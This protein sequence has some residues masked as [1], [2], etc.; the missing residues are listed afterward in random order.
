MQNNNIFY[1]QAQNIT[2][3]CLP[4]RLLEIDCRLKIIIFS[5]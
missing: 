4:I 3:I 5:S 1:F 2:I